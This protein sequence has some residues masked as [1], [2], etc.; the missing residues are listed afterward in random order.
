MPDIDGY[1]DGAEIP[2]RAFRVLLDTRPNE[3]GLRATLPINYFDGGDA[4]QNPRTAPTGPP[5][6]GGRWQSP[7][8]DGLGWMTWGDSYYANAAIIGDTYLA[9]AALCA[10]KCWFGS[11]T[12]HSDARTQEIHTWGLARLTGRDHLARPNA[13][14]ELA[15]PRGTV[16][17]LTG[18]GPGGN[19]SGVTYDT[20]TNKLYMI[21]Y[22]GGP[23][24]YT[25]RLYRFSV[26]RDAEVPALS[27]Q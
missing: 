10:G 11:S 24:V 22:P 26:A 13:M 20:E 1:A 3:R 12:L 6:S 17:G 8:R 14:E 4:R 25:G 2:S 9:V 16:W 5:R 21:I 18:N 15:L 23:D 27:A 19:V 7:N